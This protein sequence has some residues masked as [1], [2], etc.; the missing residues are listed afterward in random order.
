MSEQ[1]AIGLGGELRSVR[2]QLAAQLVGV[3][4]D[5]VVHDRDRA[6]GV[7]MRIGVARLPLR[8]TPG[9]ND[10]GAALDPRGDVCCQFADSSLGLADPQVTGPAE[11][12]K[13]G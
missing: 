13:A 5:A 9:M 6:A 2:G 3:L 7:R 10:A 1:L 8:C 4:D 12:G 11:N